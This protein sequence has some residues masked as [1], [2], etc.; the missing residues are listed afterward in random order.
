MSMLRSVSLACGLV[1]FLAGSAHA[2]NVTY[3]L[4]TPGV[5]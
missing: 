4:E 3:V 1:L 5:V 2:N